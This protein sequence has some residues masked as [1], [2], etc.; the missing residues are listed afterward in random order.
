MDRC[1]LCQAVFDYESLLKRVP[2]SE[3]YLTSKAQS[4]FVY[5]CSLVI[6]SR[7]ASVLVALG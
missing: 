6:N 3:L 5:P 4:G 7:R 1:S 2:S